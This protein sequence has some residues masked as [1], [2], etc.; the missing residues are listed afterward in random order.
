MNNSKKTWVWFGLNVLST[1]T[2]GFLGTNSLSR[3]I[4]STI[5]ASFWIF[6]AVMTIYYAYKWINNHE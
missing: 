5:F 3:L 4:A 2:M 6:T 1:F